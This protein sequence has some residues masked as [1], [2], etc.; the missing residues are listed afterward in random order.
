VS[1][2]GVWFG[3]RRAGGAGIGYLANDSGQA[4]SF[5]EALSVANDGESLYLTVLMSRGGGGSTGE[6]KLTMEGGAE[7]LW[8][9]FV[10]PLQ[11]S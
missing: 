6:R 9:L 11:R 7:L 5:N 1:A 8:S 3:G 2:C 4:G 10:D